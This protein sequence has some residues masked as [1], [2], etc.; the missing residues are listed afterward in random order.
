MGAIAP[1]LQE[2]E[3]RSRAVRENPDGLG[4]VGYAMQS[5]F[6][7]GALT[8]IDAS[9]VGLL[10]YA[11]PALVL[12]LAYALRRERPGR[13]LRVIGEGCVGRSVCRRRAHEHDQVVE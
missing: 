7:F 3:A 12:L 13:Q 2:I 1:R 4:A 8:R 5:A 9:L 11:Y 6:Y 10:L